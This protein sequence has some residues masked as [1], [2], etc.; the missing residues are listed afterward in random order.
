MTRRRFDNSQLNIAVNQAT[1]TI[2]ATNIT[3]FNTGNLV[4]D[5]VYVIDG[6][7]CDAADTTGCDQI[8]ELIAGGLSSSTASG[9]YTIP[10]GIA[11]DQVTDTIYANLQA[12][13]DYAS[14]V[15]VING[16]ICNGS[17]LAGCS[18]VPPRVAAG[19][20][21]IGVA[22]DPCTHVV[23]TTNLYDSS[24]SVIDGAI[25]NRFISF[26]CGLVPPKLPSGSF[27]TSIAVDPVV[28]TVYVASRNFGISVLPL[29]P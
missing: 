3:G 5:G 24:V 4:G 23:Y 20:N 13:G 11:V 12:S 28:G 1:N 8:P 21:A 10:W 19:F 9:P 2:Y 6:A 29:A 25:C 22:V 17:D 7:V 14:S 27:P 18:Q 15:L 16:A 26:G